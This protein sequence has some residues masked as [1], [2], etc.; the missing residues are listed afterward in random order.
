MC[1]WA[2]LNL[3]AI[4]SLAAVLVAAG[5]PAAARAQACPGYE[6]VPAL[7]EGRAYDPAEPGDTFVAF[8]L[9]AAEPGLPKACRNTQVTLEIVGGTAQ[10]P[11]L[12]G[13]AGL[14]Q[15]DW[16][17]DAVVRRNGPRFRLTNE[18]RRSL[19]RGETLH[20][21]LYR[22]PAGQYVDTGEYEQLLRF[23]AGR[24]EVLFPLSVQV[25]AALRFEG[26]SAQGVQT[27]DLGE[28][29]QGGRAS[30]DF[31]F[32]T[33][34][35]V[36]VTLISDNRGVLVHERGPDFGAIA[37]QASLSGAPVDLTGAGGAVL[38]GRFV[39][40]GIQTGRLTVETGPARARYAGRYRDVITLTFIPY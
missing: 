26:D 11:D 34:A 33:N 20:F 36:A 28:V 24:S 4:V 9:R 25:E 13:A 6:L 32:R 22:L 10:D 23:S 30:S 18:A 1:A 40:G 39:G 38:R 17:N 8:E 12:R 3:R 35:P 19:S 27:L 29:S 15:A 7:S 14:L 16:E 21:R 31:V 5:L 37:Y 2:T